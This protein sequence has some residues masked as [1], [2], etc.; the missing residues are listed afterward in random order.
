MQVRD[1]AWS[2]AEHSGLGWGGSLA[3]SQEEAGVLGDSVQG[4]G[5]EGVGP[6]HAKEG[7]FHRMYSGYVSEGMENMVEI[8]PDLH[9]KTTVLHC[10]E[11]RSGGGGGQPE[12]SREPCREVVRQAERDDVGGGA[13]GKKDGVNL[14]IHK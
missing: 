13:P 4:Q 11:R 1:G 2:S 12:G 10:L 14:K 9:F 3:Y 7:G 6:G 5:G 8:G